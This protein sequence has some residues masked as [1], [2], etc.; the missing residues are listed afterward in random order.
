MY[1]AY[2]A[3]NYVAYYAVYVRCSI[4]PSHWLS[5]S[6]AAV[7]E[8]VL[9]I[10]LIILLLSMSIYEEVPDMLDNMLEYKVILSEDFVQTSLWS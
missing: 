6:C 7:E 8:A 4:Q 9:T 1:S 2:Y 3:P 10:N 5:L